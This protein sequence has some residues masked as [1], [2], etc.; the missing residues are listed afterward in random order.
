MTG[1]VLQFQDYHEVKIVLRVPRARQPVADT[2]TVESM[3]GGSE[4]LPET[5]VGVNGIELR[6]QTHEEALLS[7]LGELLQP[8]H[9][10]AVQQAGEV[11]T[12]QSD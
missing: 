4:A 11:W 9:C 12:A 5:A 7:T 2:R 1:Q 10:L 8:G 6:E 3:P